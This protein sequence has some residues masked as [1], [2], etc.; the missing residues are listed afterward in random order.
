MNHEQCVRLLAAYDEL[1]VDDRERVDEHLAGCARCAAVRDEYRAMDADLRALEDP[2]PGPA[3]RQAIRGAAEMEHRH[4][5]ARALPVGRLV[6]AGLL[7]A[8]SL[9]AWLVMR[10]GAPWSATRGPAGSTVGIATSPPE[11]RPTPTLSTPG[12]GVAD[13]LARPPAP[14]ET[15]ELDAYYSGAGGGGYLRRGG[16]PPPPDQVACPLVW[17]SALTD[18]PFV[19]VL[20]LLNGVRSNALPEDG[21]WLAAVTPEQATPGVRTY[22]DLPYHARLRGRFGEPAFAH[23]P[24]AER[25]FV[26]EEVVTVYAEEAP[27]APAHALPADY[28]DWPR[29]H[30]AGAGYSLPYPPGWRI[31]RTDDG[32]LALTPP[33]APGHALVVRVHD[34]ETRHDQ[35]DP[36]TIPGLLEGSGWSVYEQG[37]AYGD[38]EAPDSQL[39]AGYHV[40][41][42][43]GEGQAESAVLLSAHGRTYELT[44][45]H[46]TGYAARQDVLSA[47]TAIV[48]GFRLDAAP[49]PSPTPPVRQDLGTG[50]FLGREEALAAVRARDGEEVEL[51]TAALLSEAEARR[52]AE[53]CGT[54]FGHPEGVWTLTVRGEYEGQ[55]R[56]MRLCLDAT[57]GE[58][59]CGEEIAPFATAVATEPARAPGE[60]VSAVTPTPAS[61]AAADHWPRRVHPVTAERPV[62]IPTVAP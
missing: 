3:L 49:A 48:E 17:E 37:W 33:D 50:P 42:A 25:V 31:G 8:L 47:M 24:D 58:Q 16:P 10:G 1:S 44:L 57:T 4:R 62:V 46:A 54:F 15:V 39:L 9:G 13:L 34:G 6:Q 19:P 53:A 18:R 5:A 59:L 52:S 11:P 20:S 28:V 55:L 14:G 61:S 36:S 38:G 43:R 56:T 45:R 23:C 12:P 60:P 26:V 21:A 30:D 51:L 27:A 41:R 2:Q 7:V 29:H 40:E 35:Y 22:P 32:G